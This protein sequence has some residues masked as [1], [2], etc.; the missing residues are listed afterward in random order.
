[1]EW[2]GINFIT[3]IYSGQ[4]HQI[5]MMRV[6]LNIYQNQLFL[7]QILFILQCINN[8]INYILEILKM[9]QLLV[10]IVDI[11]TSETMD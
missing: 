2:I 8:I 1:M 5:L 3:F 7:Y 10:D 6:S 4:C 11:S 9:N